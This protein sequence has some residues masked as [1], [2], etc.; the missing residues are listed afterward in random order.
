MLFFFN[1][2]NCFNKQDFPFVSQLRWDGKS[3]Q[4]N[5]FL[6]RS[7]LTLFM[8]VVFLV[9]LLERIKRPTTVN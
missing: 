9:A 8:W 7:V 6:R 5:K 2:I 1:T 3:G 4:V